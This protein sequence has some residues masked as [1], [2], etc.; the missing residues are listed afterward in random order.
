MPTFFLF[1]R[2]SAEMLILSLTLYGDAVKII[3]IMKI[4]SK[5]IDKNFTPIARSGE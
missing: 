4:N 1:S 2:W 3:D 5:M